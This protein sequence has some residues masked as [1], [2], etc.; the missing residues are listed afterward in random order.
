MARALSS[1]DYRAHL[2]Q[3]LIADL[4]AGSLQSR[5]ELSRVGAH[6]GLP[7]RDFIANQDVLDIAFKVRN[8]I[9]HE[10]DI[11]LEADLRRRHRHHA[12]MVEYTNAVFEV[13]DRLLR[14]VDDMLWA[15]SS[16]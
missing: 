13:G 2:L 8:Q 5:E 11:D 10:M 9:T 7:S 4:T 3:A 1:P 12:D 16:R 14:R 6:F 15:V